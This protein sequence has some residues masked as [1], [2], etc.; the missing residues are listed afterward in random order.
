MVGLQHPFQCLRHVNRQTAGL[1]DILVA[2]AGRDLFSFDASNG[3]RLDVWPQPVNANPEG[4]SLGE[5]S[6]S[7]S[8]G[9]P[10]KRRKLSSPAADQKNAESD[11]KPEQDAKTKD[12][13]KVDSN[14]WTTIPLVIVAQSKYVVIM[15]AE[16]KCIRVLSLAE[17]GKLQQ[18]SAR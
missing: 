15:T 10:E 14:S 6:T 2:T 9:P 13:K 16:D 12:S 11:S 7:E 4:E 17:D 5:T 3:Q 8:Q 18:L 1:S